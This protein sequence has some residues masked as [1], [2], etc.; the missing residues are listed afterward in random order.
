MVLNPSPAPSPGQS[1]L[2]LKTL[3]MVVL[4][5]PGH[6]SLGLWTSHVP[7]FG[8]T[9]FSLALESFK[10]VW[11]AVHH[12][13][14]CCVGQTVSQDHRLPTAGL[15]TMYVSCRNKLMIGKNAVSLSTLSVVI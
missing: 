8:M 14:G 10:R 15:V 1:V 2:I 12:P 9:F 3:R 7:V 4:S 5:F 11:I 13:N 6:L